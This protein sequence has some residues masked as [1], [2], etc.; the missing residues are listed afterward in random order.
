MWAQICFATMPLQ[1]DDGAAC[2]KPRAEQ[3]LAKARRTASRVGWFGAA[4]FRKEG[5]GRVEP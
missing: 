1:S 4:L 3:R 2:P 5:L